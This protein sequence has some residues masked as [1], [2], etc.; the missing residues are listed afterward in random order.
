MSGPNTYFPIMWLS[1]K[2]TSVSRST[3]EAEVVSLAASL[4]SEAIPALD[5]WDTLL[6][7]SVKL[8]IEEDNQACIKVVKAGYS[9]KLR[10]ILRTHK[11]NLG[12]IK[13]CLDSEQIDIEYIHT[14]E[15]AADIFTCLLY[16]SPSPRDS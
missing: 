15:Q 5:F 1:K 8:R 9:Q 4:F 7:R 6:G 2:Q 10:H 14:D 13:E 16:T 3:T 12:S 11:V